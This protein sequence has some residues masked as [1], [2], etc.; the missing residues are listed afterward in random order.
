MSAVRTCTSFY[1]VLLVWLVCVP[2]GSGADFVWNEIL[3]F[4]SAVRDPSSPGTGFVSEK[5]VLGIRSRTVRLC[6]PRFCLKPIIS[7]YGPRPFGS[8]GLFFVWDEAL[9][10]RLKEPV[11]FSLERNI[12]VFAV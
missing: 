12:I 10:V 2:F 3:L 9:L 4:G 8:G 1:L 6:D 7:V 5:I 11:F